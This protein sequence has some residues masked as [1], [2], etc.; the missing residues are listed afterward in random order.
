[1]PITFH[2]T[3]CPQCHTTFRITSQQLALRDGRA[4]CGH[5]RTVF[6][7]FAALVDFA[8][9]RVPG[10][11]MEP[12]QRETMTLR[13]S[14]SSSGDD[15][16]APPAPEETKEEKPSPPPVSEAPADAPASTTP[17]RRKGPPTKEEIALAIAEAAG[18][19]PPD[20]TSAPASTTPPRRKGPPTK[21]EV[22][23]AIAEAAGEKPQGPASAPASTTPPRRKGPPTKEEIALAI[24]ETTEERRQR[25]LRK[26]KPSPLT[27][28]LDPAK[29]PT[30]WQRLHLPFWC[31]PLFYLVSLP[32]LTALLAA[33]AVFFLHDELASAYPKLTPTIALGCR[34]LNCEIK[35]L[36]NLDAL[37]IEASDLQSIPNDA[38]QLLLTITLRNRSNKPVAYPRL[39]LELNDAQGRLLTRRLFAPEAY[40]V[41]AADIDVG[42]P[43]AR[44]QVL[45]LL[46][47]SE[48][49][50]TG[51]RLSLVY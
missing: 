43:P 3:R 14:V 16:S 32:V 38:Q 9:E 39:S 31:R 15:F 42:A 30:I 20:P 49:P 34:W 18:E 47:R 1:M 13:D 48:F 2:Y 28:V 35:P 11:G 51:Y 29:K 36:Q 8:G 5:C 41:R 22:A 23:L 45:R 37:T 24:A 50:A 25:N 21:E 4:R 10:P 12:V 26:E 33:Q 40:L 17:P 46:L 6:N 19:K 44:D 27:L 7:A